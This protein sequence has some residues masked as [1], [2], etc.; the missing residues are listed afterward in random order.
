[1]RGEFIAKSIRACFATALNFHVWLGFSIP[2]LVTKMHEH[3]NI[4]S[5]FATLYSRARHL[6]CWNVNSRA[7]IQ[8][9][10]WLKKLLPFWGDF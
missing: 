7:I 1:M 6:T 9:A 4:T 2:E 3:L 10:M 8:V 5:G